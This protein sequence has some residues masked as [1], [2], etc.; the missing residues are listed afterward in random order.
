[1]LSEHPTSSGWPNC[2]RKAASES[3]FTGWA[4][5]VD[6]FTCAAAERDPVRIPSAKT[7]AVPARIAVCTRRLQIREE[8]TREWANDTALT[9]PS[10]GSLNEKTVTLSRKTK[11]MT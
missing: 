8:R 1:M 5:R 10:R 6:G 11:I 9:S 3:N 4:R 7:I 2:D